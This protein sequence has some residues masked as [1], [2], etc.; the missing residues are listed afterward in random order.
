MKISTLM[1]DY[2]GAGLLKEQSIHRNVLPRTFSIE[3]D[4]PL[5]PYKNEWSYAADPERLHRLF[6]FADS[7]Q[8]SL[9]VEEL[10]SAED[11]N[12]HSAKITITASEVLVEVWTHD[13]NTVTELDKEYASMC[14]ELYNDVSL[15]GFDSHE[16]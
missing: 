4:L 9:F 6:R 7:R 16:Y 12:G 15:I 1:K 13:I 11:A 10:L 2:L 3:S 5:E 14:D 8:R